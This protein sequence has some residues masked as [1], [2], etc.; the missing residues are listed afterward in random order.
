MSQ[1]HVHSWM[2]TTADNYRKCTTCPVALKLVDGT[3]VEMQPGARKKRQ[4]KS[5]EEC[6]Y[7]ML[8]TRY[9]YDTAD[10]CKASLDLRNYWS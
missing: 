8:N 1:T 6:E 10:T 4:R 9:R 3:W 7:D 2:S 5:W